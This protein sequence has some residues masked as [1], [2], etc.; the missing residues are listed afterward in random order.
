M[1]LSDPVCIDLP[2]DRELS[3][4]SVTT[5]GS[6]DVDGFTPIIKPPTAGTVGVGRMRD[7]LTLL[8]G[9]IDIAPRLT[10]SLTCN[11]SVLDGVLAA[12]FC[13]SVVAYLASPESQE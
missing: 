6:F 4:F 7:E 10:L 9:E 8:D 3:T 1:T 2:T 12:R 11:H 5:L 13:Q